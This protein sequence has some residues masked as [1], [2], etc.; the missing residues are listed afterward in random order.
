M[1]I[2]PL[3]ITENL[4][5]EKIIE[6]A[7]ASQAVPSVILLWLFFTI[8]SLIVGMIV[9]DTRYGKNKFLLTWIIITILSGLFALWISLSPIT[10]N[11]LTSWAK[12]WIKP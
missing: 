12:S 3:N 9:Y 8:I 5:P 11:E 1:T 2:T 7:H 10:I 6:I 4:L